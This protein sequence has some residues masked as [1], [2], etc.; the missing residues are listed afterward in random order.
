[1]LRCAMKVFGL[2]G[3]E[4]A[5]GCPIH[6]PVLCESSRLRMP[7]CGSVVVFGAR[8]SSRAYQ[9][10]ALRKLVQLQGSWFAMHQ[11]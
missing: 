2:P 1:M 9:Q 8:F 3:V 4:P 11:G 6:M 10:L 7:Q 5:N